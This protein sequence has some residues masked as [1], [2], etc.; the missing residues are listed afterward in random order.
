MVETTGFGQGGLKDMQEVFKAHGVKPLAEEKFAVSDTD[1][2]SQLNKMRAAGVDTILVWAQGTPTGQLVRSMD[3]INYFPTLLSSWAADNPSFFDA[4]GKA[5]V[6]KPLFMRTMLNPS[7]PA[8]QKL[9]ARVAPKLSAP[10]SFTFVSHG[11]DAT[12]V[13]VAAIKQAGSIDG[14]KMREALEDL[15]APVVGVMKT[16]EKPFSQTQHE[17]LR[18]GDLVFA[19]W[20]DDKIVA[21]VDPILKSLT[22]SD[23]KR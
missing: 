14:I 19:K 9:F 21:Y 15:K 16:Y 4:A 1:M 10:S 22:S 5:L 12:L 17:G 8:Q 7:T 18:A 13:L 3:K 20:S 11:Y 2:T 6:G 23:F